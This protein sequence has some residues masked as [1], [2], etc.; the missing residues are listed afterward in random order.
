[1]KLLV[2]YRDYYIQYN[3]NKDCEWSLLDHMQADFSYVSVKLS[4]GTGS[5]CDTFCPHGEAH[6]SWVKDRGPVPGAKL[7]YYDC[8]VFYN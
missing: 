3:Y 8:L 4:L 2:K 6:C 5:H 1:M 7:N